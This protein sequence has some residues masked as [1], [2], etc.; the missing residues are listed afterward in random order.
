MTSTQVWIIILLLGGIGIF[1]FP[2][3]SKSDDGYK[4]TAYLIGGTLVTLTNGYS[5]SVDDVAGFKTVTKYFGNEARGDLNNDGL[6]DVAF[7]VIQTSGGTG[8][9]YY[10]V[11]A[12]KTPNGYQG[13]NGVLLGDRVSPKSISIS[14]NQIQAEF[15]VRADDAPMV[16]EPTLE[17]VRYLQIRGYQ[18]EMIA[19]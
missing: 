4:N 15:L 11:A 14:Q 10:V 9:F 16:A 19:G 7:V 12:L 3:F 2:Y 5:E 6:E 18:L 17:V 1:A 13:M 8:T